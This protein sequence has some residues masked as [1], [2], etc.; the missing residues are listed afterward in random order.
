MQPLSDRALNLCRLI[1]AAILQLPL[2]GGGV[3]AGGHVVWTTGPVLEQRLKQ[4]VDVRWSGKPLRDAI[5]SLSQTQQVAVLIDRRVD[6]G[7]KLDLAI[8]GSPME[9]VLQ[10]IADRCGASVSQLGSVVY[11][12]PTPVAQQLPAVA[13][14]F[15][16]M[17]RQ[18]PK[19]VQRKFSTLKATTW[20]D[21]ATPRGLLEQL[22]VQNGLEIIGLERVPHDLW[23]AADLPPLSLVDRLTLIAV[24]FDLTFA[25]AEGGAKLEL[26]PIPE[27]LRPLP[28]KRKG[29]SQPRPTSKSSA[30]DSSASIERVR[31][32]RMSV[33]AKPLGGVLRQMAEQLGLELRI[34]EKAIQEAG[35]S[36]DQPVSAKVENAT[37]DELL[38]A[39]LQSTGLK[40]Q[41]HQRVVEIMPAE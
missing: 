14:G 26:V 33:Q 24:Q 3:E 25:V 8:N 41:R 34:D 22:A 4:A 29:V 31:V 15:E 18:Q 21:L 17:V 7:Q 40:F 20:E 35:I 9:T 1:A 13:A 23:A 27:N 10:T 28:V 11:L 12:G 5:A 2:L 6:P 37:V 38:L 39:L 16:K 36:L 30:A 19:T 32:E